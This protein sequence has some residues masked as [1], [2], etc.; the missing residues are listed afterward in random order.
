MGRMVHL[1]L[2]LYLVYLLLLVMGRMAHPLLVLYL[3]LLMDELYLMHKVKLL[4]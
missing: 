4:I 3:F 2:V 1:L